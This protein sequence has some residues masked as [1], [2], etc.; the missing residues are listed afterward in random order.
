MTTQYQTTLK[1][2]LKPWQVTAFNKLKA[3]KVSALFMDMGTGKTRTALEFINYRIQ[4]KKLDAVFWLAP[5]TTLYNLEKEIEKHSNFDCKILMKHSTELICLVGYESLSQSD[6]FCDVLYNKIKGHKNAF[7]ILDESHFVK[8]SR[9]KRTLF[10]K[11]ITDLCKYKMLMTGT[12]ITQ[13]VWD[14]YTQFEFLD[15]RILGYKSFRSFARVHLE[16]SDKYR[17]MITDVFKLDYIYFKIAPYV[18]QITKNECFKIDKTFQNYYYR[19]NVSDLQEEIKDDFFS[20][21]D[22]TEDYNILFKMLTYLHR[23]ASGYLQGTFLENT[24]SYESDL[25]AR[26]VCDILK[27]IDL[28]EDKVVVWYRYDSDLRLLLKACNGMKYACFNGKLSYD[29]KGES[30]RSFVDGDVNLMFVNIL[31][32][33]HGLNLQCANY[34]IYYNNVFDLGKRLQSV[35]RLVR[36]G[37]TKHVHIIDVIQSGTI[38]DRIEAS[39]I[40]KTGLLKELRTLIKEFQQDK[41]K[42]SEFKRLF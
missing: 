23:L 1:T 42:F 15:S 21:I 13:G 37:Q 28:E 19:G 24:Y 9:A 26:V 41:A 11:R 39:L 7:L 35:D 38:D 34:A 6:R 32:G 17:G 29:E 2:E 14:L 31:I 25:R 12:P 30:L 27:T 20:Y 3:V 33:A 4:Y 18:Y 16:Y 8:N 10:L 36:Y 22:R 5:L 40:S